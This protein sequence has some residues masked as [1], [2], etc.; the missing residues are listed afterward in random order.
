[1]KRKTWKCKDCGYITTY[2]KQQYPCPQCGSE[3]KIKIENM[4]TKDINTCQ[5]NNRCLMEDGEA[6]KRIQREGNHL[7][8]DG[9]LLPACIH[10]SRLAVPYGGMI[11]DFE[12]AHRCWD[13]EG[14]SHCV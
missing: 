9:K 6:R 8:L 1:M 7:L 12:C 5:I 10:I 14:V 2:H 3:K 4:K 11:V 13:G